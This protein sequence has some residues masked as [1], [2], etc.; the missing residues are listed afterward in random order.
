MMDYKLMKVE[1]GSK[2]PKCLF[3]G[4]TFLIIDNVLTACMDCGC[5]FVLKSRRLGIR[6]EIAEKQRAEGDKI[7]SNACLSLVVEEVIEEKRCDACGFVAK[8]EIGLK[9]HKA[10]HRKG[11]R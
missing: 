2:C 6:Q 8:T 1:D 5:V 3:I 11:G 7:E 10:K 9:V 4:R